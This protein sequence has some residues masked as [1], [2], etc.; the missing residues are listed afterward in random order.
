MHPTNKVCCTCPEPPDFDAEVDDPM[1]K[2]INMCGCPSV[3]IVCTSEEKT[4]TLCGW[5]INPS[6]TPAVPPVRYKKISVTGVG[7]A[8]TTA[9]C[10]DIN[11]DFQ[12]CYSGIFSLSGTKEFIAVGADPSVVDAPVVCRDGVLGANS[13]SNNATGNVIRSQQFDDDEPGCPKPL[14]VAFGT[15]EPLGGEILPPGSAWAFSCSSQNSESPSPTRCVRDIGTYNFPGSSSTDDDGET[16]DSYNNMQLVYEISMPDTETD[17]LARE[18][19]TTGSSCSS[20]NEL[21]TTSYSWTER[22]VTYTATASNLVIGVPYRGC[23]RLRR[24][25]AYSGTLPADADT[26]WEDVE[27]DTIASFTPTET[28][29][30]VATDEALPFVKG[31]EYEVVSAHVWPVSAGCDCPTSYVAPE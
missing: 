10:T 27:P 1:A 6:F 17:A 15:N 20:I 24:R 8:K 25:E 22:T 9:S 31:W 12:L 30:E 19:A 26:A 21:R 11:F 7:S 23:V 14:G 3:A 5:L 28:S 29:E 13:I 4:A 2:Y 16:F 18:T